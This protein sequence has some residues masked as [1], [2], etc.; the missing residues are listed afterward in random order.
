MLIV[1]IHPVMI[2]LHIFFLFFFPKWNFILVFLVGMNSS[3]D[4]IL[5]R[6][7]Y[8]NS[9]RYFIIDKDGFILGRVSSLDQTSRVN[10]LLLK[11]TESFKN[12]DPQNI[13]EKKNWIH[14]IPTRRKLRST[15]YPWVKYLDPRNSHRKKNW[16][17]KIPTRKYFGS[18]KY[19]REKI[20]DPRV[21]DGPI[22]QDSRYPWWQETHRI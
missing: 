20:S 16:T 13:H 12:L 8:V 4:E 19:P 21:H 7:K 5:S 11:F 17:S 3:R 18:M 15:K 10:T 1:K 6:R 9:K 2:C 22:T 14:G